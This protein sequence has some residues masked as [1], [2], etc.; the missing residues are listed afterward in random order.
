MDTPF[1][2][3]TPAEALHG[4]GIT[5]FGYIQTREIVFSGEVRK[6]CEGNLCRNYGKTWACPPAVGT[7]E[8]CRS[9]CLRY[10]SAFV[11]ASV[12]NLEDSFDYEG[13]MRGH[14][15]FKEVCDRL[16]ER[17]RQPCLLL[18]NEGC[19]RC[20]SCT[21]PAQPCRFPDR[22]FPS[23]EGYGILVN[24]LAKT[25]GIPYNAGANT[26]SYFGLV[27]YGENDSYKP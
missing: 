20:Q 18:S 14:R 23:L 6:L 10:A 12:Y 13:M 27:C 22:L 5:S 15:Q 11:F 8:E 1:A 17:L 3:Q 25:A 4:I 26:V 9:R 7:F 2:V 21:Y 24:E 16:H 19:I